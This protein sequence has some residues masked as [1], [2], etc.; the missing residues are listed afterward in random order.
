MI[1]MDYV[2]LPDGARLSRIFLG[3]HEYLP[4]GRSRGFNEDLA[5]A[6]QP[7]A[8]FPGFGGAERKAVLARAYD[9][10]I[11]VFDVTL[12]A[13]K[14]AL[15][16]NLAEMP[17]PYEVFVQTR[18][19]GMVYG[20]DPGNLKM[21]DPA[22]LRA[23]VQRILKLLRRERLDLLN[24]GILKPARDA[25]GAYLQQLAENIRSLQREGLIRFAAADSFSG[26]AT[27]LA[28]IATGAFAT[29]NVN[30]NLADDGPERRV[31]PAAKTGGMVVVVR[32]ALIKGELFR[33][34]REAGIADPARLARAKWTASR[35][36]VDAVIVGAGT[37][38]HLDANVASALTPQLD[39]GELGLLDAFGRHPAVAALQSRKRGEFLAEAAAD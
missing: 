26:E 1:P 6:V 18:P 30:L 25:E 5:R 7:G 4:D 17:P 15:G 34:G 31:I 8:T 2:T 21:A 35:P 22:L 38:D 11:T 27:Y 24:L 9:L 32:E 19:E 13:E 23:E 16:R 3:G 14:E 28:M 20:Y 36:G 29:L 39:D 37:V 33:L 10:G 12:D